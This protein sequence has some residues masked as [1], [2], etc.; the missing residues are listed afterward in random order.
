[1]ENDKEI[2]GYRIANIKIKR[3]ER[4]KLHAAI[5]TS[6]SLNPILLGKGEHEEDQPD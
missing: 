2:V 5:R 6:I 1:M 3:K 4:N